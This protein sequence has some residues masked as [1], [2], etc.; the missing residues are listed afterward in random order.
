VRVY[1]AKRDDNEKEIVQALRKFEIAVTQI[2]AAGVPDLLCSF[3][4]H[5]F[6]VEVKMKKGKLR[7]AQIEFMKLHGDKNVFVIRSA[8]D[9]ERLY[10]EYFQYSDHD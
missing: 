5:F 9:A 8:E 6:F 1:N 4:S 10:R 2:S 3:K 7:D